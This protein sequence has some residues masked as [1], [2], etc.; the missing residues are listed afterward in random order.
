MNGLLICD[1]LI[2]TS[3]VTATAR[4]KGLHVL[5]VRSGEAALTAAANAPPAC[6]IVDL[7]NAGLDIEVLLV[8]L[9]AA[10]RTMPRVVGFGSHVDVETLRAA[11]D[12][13]CDLVMPRSQFVKKLE[14]DLP[15]WFGE[16]SREQPAADQGE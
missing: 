8:G 6:V 3:K 15:A 1:D 2:F 7:H 11:R 5:P 13:G 14:S 10:C 4:A 12:A 16:P 9:R